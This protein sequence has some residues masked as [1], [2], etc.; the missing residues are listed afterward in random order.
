[1]QLISPI[2]LLF[3]TLS[4]ASQHK[5]QLNLNKTV[6]LKQVRTLELKHSELVDR[7][8]YSYQDNLSAL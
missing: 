1:M 5:L 6:Y 8:T 7:R 4:L 2:L 3:L